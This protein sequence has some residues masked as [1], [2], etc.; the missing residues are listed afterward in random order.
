MDIDN[1]GRLATTSQEKLGDAH[2]DV[3]T[4]ISAVSV[5]NC[6]SIRIH[7]GELTQ[8]G[9][10]IELHITLEVIIDE[11]H[12]QSKL[13][14]VLPY[15][16]TIAHSLDIHCSSMGYCAINDQINLENVISCGIETTTKALIQ[17]TS[18]S[19]T[20]HQLYTCF[21]YKMN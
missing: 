1:M 9:R 19:T 16:T 5:S 11:S 7:N 18:H 6:H 10:N 15:I 14:I 4:Q 2:L 13:E 12:T 17:F 20:S 8:N 3:T 21:R